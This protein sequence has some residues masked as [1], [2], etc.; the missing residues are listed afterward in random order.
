M[1]KPILLF[2]VFLLIF[3]GFFSACKKTNDCDYD[4]DCNCDD[5]TIIYPQSVPFINYSL[6]ESNCHW[7]YGGPT[8]MFINNAEEMEK[9]IKCT[10]SD[11]PFID[12]S[13]YTLLLITWG[14]LITNCGDEYSIEVF[15]NGDH[16]YSI[17]LSIMPNSAATIINTSIL[18][19]KIDNESVFEVNIN[20]L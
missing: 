19:P 4:Y 9:I 3:A 2:T 15:K 16:N 11:Y 18:I 5:P 8:L 6:E 12:F 17:N 13:N 20:F 14:N 7:Y 1:K 10:E